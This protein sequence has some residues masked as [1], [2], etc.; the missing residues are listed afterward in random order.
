MSIVCGSAVLY[1][2]L[3]IYYIFRNY[4]KVKNVFQKQNNIPN[5]F[6]RRTYL[7]YKI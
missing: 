7:A 6:Y 2:R 1:M 4:E 5:T 3:L